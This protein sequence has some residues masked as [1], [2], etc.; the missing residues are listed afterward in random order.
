[1]GTD[2]SI[3]LNLIMALAY[4]DLSYDVV[5]KLDE[6]LLTS[7]SNQTKQTDEGERRGERERDGGTLITWL[8]RLK[9]DKRGYFW[10]LNYSEDEMLNLVQTFCIHGDFTKSPWLPGNNKQ[11]ETAFIVTVLKFWLQMSTLISWR[12]TLLYQFCSPPNGSNK[13]CRV[14]RL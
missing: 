4:M 12:L 8:V 10:T 7:F 2:P 1:M 14:G 6:P 5:L 9:W 3:C 13:V 11:K